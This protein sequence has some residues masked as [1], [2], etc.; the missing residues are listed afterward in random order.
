MEYGKVAMAPL[1]W[2]DGTGSIEEARQVNDKLDWVM[3]QRGR[4][5]NQDK[6]V[7]PILGKKKMSKT[8]RQNHLCVAVLSQRRNNKKKGWVRFCYW[9]V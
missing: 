3:K 1:L 5:L 6:Y 9:L 7:C 8:Y 2:M 4:T